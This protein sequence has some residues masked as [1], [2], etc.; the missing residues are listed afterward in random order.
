MTG[1]SHALVFATD[2]MPSREL[3]V[4][5]GSFNIEFDKDINPRSRSAVSGGT[6]LTR[7]CADAEG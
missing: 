7:L 5:D 3:W 6:N 2:P 4:R 1:T